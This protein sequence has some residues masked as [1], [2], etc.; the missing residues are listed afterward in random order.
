MKILDLTSFLKFEN[1][2][3]FESFCDDEIFLYAPFY[4]LVVAF[5]YRFDYLC[6][7]HYDRETLDLQLAAHRREDR[8]LRELLGFGAR[9][10]KII[11]KA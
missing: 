11:D 8:I 4:E 7:G 1:R 3:L 6:V 9:V 5:V 10:G 2:A